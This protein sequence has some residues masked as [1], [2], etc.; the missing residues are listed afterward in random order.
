MCSA[1]RVRPLGKT[2]LI[3][4]EMSL[5][6]WALSGHAYGP[7]ETPAAEKVIRR[8]VEIGLTLLETADSYAGG[9]VEL[10]LGKVL[11]G[12]KDA[13]VVTKIGVD[14][15]TTPPRKRF[16]AAYL[17]EAVARS[18]KRLKREKLDV[19]LL[20]NPSYDALAVGDAVATM[21]ALKKDGLVAHWGVAAGDSET[22]RTAIDKGAEVIEVAYNLLHPIDLHRVAGDVMVARCGVLARSTLN[23]GMLAG[24]WAKDHVF[25]EHDDHRAE[26]WTRLE[27]ERRV[28]QLA[29]LR[30]LVKGDV[31]T[32]RAAAVRYVLANHLVSSAVLGPR[33]VEQLEQLVRETGAGP[34]YLSDDDLAA[35]P[36]A[37]HKV[38]ILS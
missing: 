23:Y 28:E 5:G 25:G 37:L 12:N 27:L 36:R 6:T 30:F 15:T 8:A 11:E 31:L 1:V 3:V 16:E 17:R 38:G 10:L 2:G 7:V 22:A 19:C 35:L 33:T 13:L 32:L 4:P 18:L 9:G 26:R 29:A 20:H 24:T 21:E 34:R 14:V